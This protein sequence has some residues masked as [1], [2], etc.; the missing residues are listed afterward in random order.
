MA[1]SG[2]SHPNRPIVVRAAAFPM[3]TQVVESDQVRP[4]SA[5]R[6]R[7]TSCLVETDQVRPIT[8]T[9][10]GLLRQVVE[11]D[12]VSALVASKRSQLGQVVETSLVRPMQRTK[13]RVLFKVTETDTVFLF[14]NKPILS[15]VVEADQARPVTGT[16]IG[17]LRQVVETGQA[18][19]AQFARAGRLA[20]L[21]EAD[22]VR[23]LTGTKVG[24][25]RQ[26]VESDSVGL[27]LR[28]TPPLWV[29]LPWRRWSARYIGRRG[30]VE[31]ISSESREWVPFFV[32]NALGSEPAEIAFTT[33]G[34]EPVESDWRAAS[35]AGQNSDGAIAQVLIGPGT[36]SALAAGTYQGWVRVTRPDER[37]VLPSGLVPII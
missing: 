1:R 5:A 31:P 26:V 27:L 33:P 35:W 22:Q 32:G 18:R 21:V 19:P 7:I 29:G 15:R 8:G 14:R 23:P 3:L 16:K 20:R 17:L 12:S 6:S 37:P 36:A 30:R 28:R 9:K 13:W 2:R 25:L 4:M 11:T 10:I 24:V 34:V